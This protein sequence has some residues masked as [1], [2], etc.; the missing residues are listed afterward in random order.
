MPGKYYEEFK[1]GKTIEHRATRTITEADNL[2]FCALTMNNQPL[3]LDEE[4]AKS[5]QFGRRVVNGIYVMGLAVGISVEDT[6][7]GTLVANLGY[8]DVEHPKPVFI[9]DTIRVKTVV[10]SKR[11]SSKPGRG[12]VEFRHV[13]VNQKGEEVLTLLRKAM[14]QTRAK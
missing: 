9:G 1:V 10:K 11:L 2:L 12:L 5:T 7:A 14:V 8:A 6:T 4:Y 13:A 3:H